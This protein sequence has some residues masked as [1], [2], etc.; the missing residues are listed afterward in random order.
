MEDKEFDKFIEQLE[1]DMRTEAAERLAIVKPNNPEL[2]ER[3]RQ[4][5]TVYLQDYPAQ[6]QSAA[7][8]AHI[9]PA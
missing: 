9:S 6:Y 4:S 8:Y 7:V 2:A 3:F 5:G 1:K